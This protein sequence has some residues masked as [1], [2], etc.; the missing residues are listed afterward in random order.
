MLRWMGAVG[1]DHLEVRL[2]SIGIL[3]SV[4]QLKW[5]RLSCREDGRGKHVRRVGGALITRRQSLWSSD[6]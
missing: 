6:A 1:E 3:V 5:M 4:M 2:E